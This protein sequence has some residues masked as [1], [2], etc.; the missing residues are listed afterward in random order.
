MQVIDKIV[1]LLKEKLGDGIVKNIDNNSSPV[2]LEVESSSIS[3]VMAIL[4]IHQELY[5]DFLNCIS[6]IDA[7][8]ENGEMEVIYHISSLPLGHHLAVKAKISRNESQARL[9]TVSHIWKSADWHERECYDLLGIHFD[10]HPDLRRILLP[11]DWP[12]HPLQKDYQ[13]PKS[14]RGIQVDY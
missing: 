2:C 7:G 10:G 6:G 9:K 4:H 5:F 13:G 1:G 12:G 8:P 14:Y 11:A 3:E